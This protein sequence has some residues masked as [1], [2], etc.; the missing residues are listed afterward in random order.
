MPDLAS[1]ALR[2]SKTVVENVLGVHVSRVQP[3]QHFYGDL[4]RLR[5][6]TPDDV[7]FDV[8]ANDGRTVM[9][10]QQVLPSPRIYA[11]EPVGSTHA[12]LAER[13]SALPNVRAFHLALGAEPGTATMHLADLSQLSSMS[14]VPRATGETETVQVST[15]DAVMQEHDVDVVHFLKIDTEGY[16]LEVLRGATEALSS[17]RIEVIQAEVGFGQAGRDFPTLEQVRQLLDP[18]GYR[19]RGMYNQ[20]HGPEQGDPALPNVLSYCDAVFVRATR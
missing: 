6:W 14:R 18:Y 1:R 10:L 5:A 17:G 15:V 3:D 7:V 11:F 9:R 16:E 8:G 13:T 2:R 20:C 4:A 19:L 12:T